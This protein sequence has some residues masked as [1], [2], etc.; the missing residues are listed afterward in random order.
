MRDGAT[1]P[2]LE[3]IFDEPAGGGEGRGGWMKFCFFFLFFLL[4]VVCVKIDW[5]WTPVNSGV[6]GADSHTIPP[7]CHTPFRRM[8]GIAASIVYRLK[9]EADRVV[10]SS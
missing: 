10:A 5:P 9:P 1:T 4:F 8:N 6:A 7:D 2:P 3:D